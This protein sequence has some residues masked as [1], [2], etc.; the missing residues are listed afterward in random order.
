MCF[1]SECCHRSPPGWWVVVVV[2]AVGSLNFR[3]TVRYMSDYCLYPFRKNSESWDPTV[4]IIN[5]QSL[6]FGTWGRSNRKWGTLRGLYPERPP[7][8]PAR[9]H[10]AFSLVFLSPEGSRSGT[11]KE[12]SFGIERLII[13]EAGDLRFRVTQSQ[14]T[15]RQSFLFFVFCCGLS[16]RY[17]CFFLCHGELAPLKEAC[18]LWPSKPV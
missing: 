16:F 3:R 4:L 12:L 2:G 7:Q 18:S 10:P 5:C 14:W 9:F 13:K 1:W 11:R 6:L 8:S 17:S 15:C